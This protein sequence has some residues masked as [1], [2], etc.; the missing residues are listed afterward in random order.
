MSMGSPFNVEETGIYRQQFCKLPFVYTQ[1]S[2]GTLRAGG[3]SKKNNCIKVASF[4]SAPRM[5]LVPE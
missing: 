2:P 4:Y 1:P 3:D 5:P